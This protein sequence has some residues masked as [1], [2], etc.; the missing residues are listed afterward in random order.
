L[1]LM[2]GLPGTGKST[3]ARAL[4]EEAGFVVVRSDVVRKE[5]AGVDFD[6]SAASEW[7]AGIYTHD[8][9]LRTYAECLRRAGALL[10][11]GKRVIVDATFGAE[12]QRIAFL[13]A[14]RALCVPALWFVCRASPD[15]VRDRISKRT[16]DVSDA[17]WGV[18]EQAR[19]AWEAAT[20]ES[21]RARIDI[22]TE[23]GTETAQSH[24]VSALT[25]RELL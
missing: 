5:L 12:E 21:E 1:V 10:L 17:D 4:A 9:T 3:V 8:F 24:A 6:R 16:G 20:P 22:D 14:A 23:R 18:Y 13:R 19:R 2:S 15:C 25:E 11:E 7:Q